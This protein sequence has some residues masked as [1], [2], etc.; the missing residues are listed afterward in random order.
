V[1]FANYAR[2]G[3]EPGRG[4]EHTVLVKYDREWRKLDAWTFPAA[5][6]D[7]WDGMSSSGGAWSHDGR[8][9]TTGHDAAELYVL[10]LP[11][12]GDVLALESMVSF[13]SEGQGIA[14]DSES[15]RLWSIQRKT[16]EVLESQLP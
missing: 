8:L 5:V 10:R 16:G 11:R 6:V 12:A 15:G 1:A 4:P 2:R 14:I 13:G 7:R 9:F 3:G